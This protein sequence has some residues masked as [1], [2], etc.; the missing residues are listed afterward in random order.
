MSLERVCEEVVRPFLV[1]INAEGIPEKMQEVLEAL[2]QLGATNPMIS[3]HLEPD[4]LK[5]TGLPVPVCKELVRLVREDSLPRATVDGDTLRPHSFDQVIGHDPFKR[6]MLRAILASKKRGT[7]MQHVLLTGPRGLGKTTLSLAIAHERGA[8]VRLLNG[9]QFST[10]QDVSSQVLQ[11]KEGDIIFIDEIHGMGKKAQE[12]LY[13]VMEDNRL[14]VSERRRGGSVMT[15]VPAPK[16]MIIG[17]TTN[18]AKMLQPFRNRFTNPYTLSFYS[19]R[20]MVMI[21][22]RSCR[23]LGFRLPDEALTHLVRHCRDN[24]RTLNG[25]L[26][27]LSN[28]AVAEER[29]DLTLSDVQ[30]LMELNGFDELGLTPFERSYLEALERQ[31]GTASIKTLASALDMEKSEVEET[32]EPWLVRE[33]WIGKTSRGRRLNRP[34]PLPDLEDSANEIW[35][36][37]GPT[38][39][40]EPPS[41]ATNSPHSFQRQTG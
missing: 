18:P 15:S 14:P 2:H 8:E 5:D 4:D 36:P 24:P 13:S 16:V 29:R 17:A 3:A 22:W 25:Y 10:A 41:S 28:Q 33:G 6:L 35:D 31:G 27:Q 30:E 20:E 21:G 1:S 12:T 40:L 38:E 23:V 9:S 26:K 32:I 37:E 7:P 39:E 34:L 19:E 11:W